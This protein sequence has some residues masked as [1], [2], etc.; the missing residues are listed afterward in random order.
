MQSNTA[1]SPQ[2]QQISSPTPNSKG[3]V[4]GLPGANK[5]WQRGGAVVYSTDATTGNVAHNLLS[6]LHR[7][8]DCQ[9]HN[10][11]DDQ[12]DYVPLC[13]T[14]LQLMERAKKTLRGGRK[15]I[16]QKVLEE[17]ALQEAHRKEEEKKREEEAN[18]DAIPES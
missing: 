12:V 15:E 3:R 4:F 1:S 2:Q 11:D 17:N 18:L 10:T 7:H 13:T 14:L 6:S 9:Q 16:A 8:H 5:G